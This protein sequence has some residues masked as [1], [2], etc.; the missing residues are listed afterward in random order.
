M[1][2]RAPKA[3]NKV[4]L[5]FSLGDGVSSGL[6][7][8]RLASEGQRVR[9]LAPPG[10]RHRRAFRLPDDPTRQIA[11][12]EQMADAPLSFDAVFELSSDDDLDRLISAVQGVG[13]AVEQWTVPERSAAIAGTEHVI[14]PGQRPLLLVFPLRRLESLTSEQFHDY[15]LHK[16]AEV[17]LDV[18]GLQGY[19]QFHA[20]AAASAAAAAAAGVGISDFEGAA[21]GYYQDIDAFL[22][23]MSKPE[24]A[25]DALEDE[26]RFIDHA[27]S[28]IGLYRIS[29]DHEV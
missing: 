14:V 18:P 1:T 2:D 19:R 11:H 5:L 8:G 6:L 4:Q 28:V 25:A 22:E 27:R 17:A 29:W 13:K 9:E 23:V 20:D 26:K 21:E 24:V 10:G 3:R 12:G 16:H 7:E 15:W